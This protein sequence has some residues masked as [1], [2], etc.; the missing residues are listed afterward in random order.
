MKVSKL[1][2]KKINCPSCG[3]PAT[4]EICA[5]CGNLT[6][7]NSSEAN[8]EYPVLDCKEI[9]MNRDDIKFMLILGAIFTLTGIFILLFFSGICKFDW[10][11]MCIFA[12][13]FIIG[14][15]G[16]ASYPLI[17]FFRYARA[18]VFG[19]K[20][21]AKVYGYLDD[22][23]LINGR[24]GQIVKLL[25]DAPEG[26]RFVLYQLQNTL[27]P[28]GIRSTVDVMVYKDDFL[29]CTNRRTAKR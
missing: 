25:I 10:W 21:Q 9:I 19:K 22:D 4:T 14:G 3:A 11:F 7:L 27:K 16:I 1:G 20:I 23:V 17:A 29:I 28:Y 8:M 26:P 18:K 24:P 15:I 2:K 13:P 12:F 5:Y 6:G